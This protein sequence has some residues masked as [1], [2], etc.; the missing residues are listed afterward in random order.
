VK[1]PARLSSWLLLAGI[2]TGFL[3]ATWAGHAT[4][5][6][7]KPAHFRRFHRLISPDALF[8][9]P[10]SMLETLAL[11]RWQPGKTLVIVG[12]N[13]ILNG[14]G[15]SPDEVW[16]LRLQSLLGDSY[17]VVNLA[18]RSAYPTQAGALV[19]ESLHRRGIPLVYVT[20]TNP[21]AGTG[22]A[23][24]PPY[25]YYYWQ[26]LYQGKLAPFPA[27]EEAIDRWIGSLPPAA[28]AQLAEDRL[29]GRLDGWFHHLSLWHHVG[30]H[31]GFTVW[32]YLVRDEFWAPRQRLADNEPAAR[33][34]AER[35]LT[36]PAGETAIARGYTA[37]LAEPDAHG[38]WQLTAAG[39]RKIADEIEV[40]FAPDL[41]PRMLMLLEVNNPYYLARLTPAEQ[42]RETFVYDACAAIWREH[43]IA[44]V[45]AGRGFEPA[46]YVDR[47]HL[48]AAGGH[49]L[50]ALVAEKIHQLAPP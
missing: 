26:A 31:Y 41:R 11:A 38:G 2:A 1:A 29:A 3:L 37:S 18:L 50:A 8:Y 7:S 40:S 28:R 39:R 33:P 45:P 20:D 35:F 13:S 16:T 23:A 12:G 34:L 9:P 25:G 10:Y 4:A 6:Y 46:D 47:P 36:D 21:L 48:S 19:A 49:R 30:Y 44:C 5:A 42:A 17:V 14:V 32:N 22:L 43:G 15:Q 24:G 27:R